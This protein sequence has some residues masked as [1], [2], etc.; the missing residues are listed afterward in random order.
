MM[1]CSE[2]TDPAEEAERFCAEL[3]RVNAGEVETAGLS[4]IAGHAAV[5]E[6]LLAV[7]PARIGSD[8]EQFHG[9]FEGWAAAVFQK[10]EEG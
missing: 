4:E 8:L 5:A 2:S 9:A 10:E 7:A 1:A 6:R 3:A